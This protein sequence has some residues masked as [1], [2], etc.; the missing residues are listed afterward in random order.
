[1][2]TLSLFDNVL[3][4]SGQAIE[5]ADIQDFLSLRQA[6]NVVPML[7]VDEAIRYMAS[8]NPRFTLAVL[9]TTEGAATQAVIEHMAH[10]DVPVILINGHAPD[11]FDPAKLAFI[12]RPFTSDD[13]E[14]AIL[15]FAA[16][17]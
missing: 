4:I 11:Q 2:K 3:I 15:K 7:T 1:M 5:V 6:A 10:I 13:L 14:N 8:D 12:A 17:A 16:P 9:A